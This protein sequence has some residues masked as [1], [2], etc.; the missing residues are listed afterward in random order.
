MEMANTESLQ[1]V[2]NRPVIL[3]GENLAKFFG[4]LAALSSFDFQLQENEILG[5][6]GPNGAGKT[7]LFNVIAGVYKPDRGIIRFRDEIISGLQPDQLCKKG[8]ARTFQITKPFL[9]LTVLENVVVGSYFGSRGNRTLKQSGAQAEEILSFVGLAHK[10]HALA[11][12]LTLVE[13]KRLE[14]ARCLCTKPSILLLDEVVGGLNL[15]ETIALVE[16]IKQVRNEGMTILMIEH[17]MKA[18][19]GVSNRIMV[20]HHGQKIAEGKPEEVVANEVVV[21]AYLG[22]KVHASS[23]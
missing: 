18:V 4:G 1:R 14:L 20:I 2:E 10:R 21:E 11:G 12:Q 5:L 13:R 7:T 17:V 19:M 6:I 23:Q 22:G 3:S 8:I 16:L 15:T 9:T